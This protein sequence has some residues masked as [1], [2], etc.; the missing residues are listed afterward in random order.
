[1][2]RIRF[3]Q[4]IVSLLLMSSLSIATAETLP[5]FETKSTGISLEWHQHE[6]DLE[7]LDIDTNIPGVTNA[8]IDSV[9]GQLNTNNDVEVINLRL[10]HQFHPNLNVFGAIGK[11]T[12]RTQTSFSSLAPGLSDLIVDNDGVAYTI[13]ATLIHKY[14]Q[15]VASV[16]IAHSRI[17]QDNNPDDIK[18]NAAI[19]SL[20]F[21]TRY[22]I[23]S[24]SLLY[25][26][27]EASYSGTVT[28]PLVGEVPVTIETE[29]EDEIQIMAGYQ[30]QLAKKLYLN[31]NIGLNGQNQFQ[32]LINKRF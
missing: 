10:D 13:G 19:P 15:F 25:Q 18:V 7:V 22:G 5:L 11:V 26:A 14:N 30:T 4:G 12:D 20:G 9:K 28:A 1:M 3:A 29:N 31:A 17:D 21:Q 6:L 16:M 23:F 8:L 27:I 32:I 24:A 2:K